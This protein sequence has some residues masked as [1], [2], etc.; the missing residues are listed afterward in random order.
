MIVFAFIAALGVRS[1][2][3]NG[4]LSSLFLVSLLSF[5]PPSPYFCLSRSKVAGRGK[6][7]KGKKVEENE[8]K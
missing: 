6:E 2:F 8:W 3:T 4:F 1:Q 5:Y 7:E